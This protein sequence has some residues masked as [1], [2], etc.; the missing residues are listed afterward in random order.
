MG[1]FSEFNK[2]TGAG[3]GRG[4][5]RFFGWITSWEK[6]DKEEVFLQKN[7]FRIAFVSLFIFLFT[8][9]TCSFSGPQQTTQT[10][11][12]LVGVVA[13]L[14]YGIKPSMP[15]DTRF[16]PTYDV[17]KQ[18]FFELD[19]M[20]YFRFRRTSDGS[21]TQVV[22]PTN[23]GTCVLVP[24]REKIGLATSAPPRYVVNM[25][26]KLS[27]VT[28]ATNLSFLEKV[29]L[30]FPDKETPVGKKGTWEEVRKNWQTV[31]AT[32]FVLVAQALDRY[33]GGLV[34]F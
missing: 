16:T 20:N 23:T 2:E 11:S 22:I 10:K 29:A 34:C 12:D 31:E 6:G 14:T 26:S 13:N 18:W 7:S 32:R 25:E 28:K 19:G 4:V 17:D 3:A 1:F 33:P 15:L 9:G 24:A 27:Y 8:L 21:I 5:N 30:F